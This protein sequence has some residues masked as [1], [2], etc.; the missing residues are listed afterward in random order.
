MVYLTEKGDRLVENLTIAHLTELY[1]LAGALNSLLH[2]AGQ[3][4]QPG[5]R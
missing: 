2:T 1:K 5:V 3:E 4:D